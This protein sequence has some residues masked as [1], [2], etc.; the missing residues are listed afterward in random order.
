M[1]STHEASQ[2]SVMG[3]L[4]AET[5]HGWYKGKVSLLKQCTP[6]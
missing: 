6:A 1:Y 5:N 2:Q 4:N 3:V